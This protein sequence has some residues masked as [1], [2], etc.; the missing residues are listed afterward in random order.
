MRLIPLLIFSF[1][2][3]ALI[4][5][6]D[7]RLVA[8]LPLGYFLS[9]QHGIWQ[10]AEPTDQ[11]F[12][13]IYQFDNLKG[14]VTVFLDE[15]LVPHI[16]AD[17]E[18]DAYFVQGYLH[19]KFRLWQ[20]EFQTRA[21]AGRISEVIGDKAIEFDKNKR[22]EGMVFA[23]ENMLKQIE[24]DPHTKME[25]DNYTAGVNAYLQTLSDSKLPIEYKLLGYVPEKWNNLKTALMGKVLS[26]TL[27]GFSEDLSMTKAKSFFSDDEMKILFPQIESELDPIVPKGTA[28]DQPAV[29]PKISGASDSFYLF[30]KD[31]VKYSAIDQPDPDNGSNNWA[32]S[33]A[34]TQSGSPILCNDP[35]LDLSLPSIWYEMQIATS[36]MNVYGTS[37]PGVPGIL[38]GFNDSIAFGFTNSQRDVRDY[39]SIKFKDSSRKQ[40]WFNNQWVDSKPR[41]EEIKI[42]GQPSVFDVVAYT[43]FGPVIY[44]SGFKSHYPDLDAVALRWK[45]HDPSNELLMWYYLN[46]A[47]NYQEYYSA[48]Q[49]L[50]CPGQNAVFA[51]KSGDIAIWQQGDFPAKWNRQGLYIMPGYDSTYMWQAEIPR[52]E[53]PHLINPVRGFVSSAN[54]RPVDSTYPYFVS[55]QFLVY[56]GAIINRKLGEMNGVTTADMMKLQTNNYNLFAETARPVLLKYIYEDSLSG[57]EKKFLDNFKAWDLTNDID[58]KAPTVF[59]IWVD[60]LKHIIFDD[61]FQKAGVDDLLP[62]DPTLIEALQKDSAFK[63]AD[64]INTTGIET[65]GSDITLAFKKAVTACKML[66]EKGELLWG[67]YKNTTIYHLLRTALMPFARTELPV[68]GG[69]HIINAVQHSH[70]P[71]WRM[72]VQL[73]KE[74]EAFVVYPGGQS[75]NPGSKYYDQFVDKWAAGEYYKAW[76]MQ[77]GQENDKRIK[78]RMSFNH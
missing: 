69:L 44:D 39:Y 2:T 49:Y 48:L 22:R 10:N 11:S 70:G 78:W 75:G 57:I 6:F 29:T 7:S 15:R 46:R 17:H 64:N 60:S 12:D 63:Y 18:E 9:P 30:K 5:L 20:M 4:V 3:I 35:H 50:S 21:A 25:C 74:T 56:R 77:K 62:S 71:S 66:D 27:S 45:A 59:K 24:A 51:S 8:P 67:K 34:K 36:Q 53:N 26:E 54:Q 33:G 28:F 40:Y 16:K 65:V 72:V 23:A 43:V 42:K 58:E 13:E 14:K 32:V 68:G 52:A 1:L 38:I 55:G 73:S 47:K 19:A 37:L 61:E 76:I 41:V 31:T